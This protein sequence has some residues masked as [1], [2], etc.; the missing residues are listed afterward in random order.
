MNHSSSRSGALPS[1][2]GAWAWRVLALV[3]ASLTVQCG[4]PN[5]P[6]PPPPPPPALTLTC[7]AAV[8]AHSTDGNPRPVQYEAPQAAGGVAPVSISCSVASGAA[9]SVG[10]T[11]VL[12]SATDAR[13]SS[14]FCSFNVRVIAPPRLAYT[15]YLAFGDSITWGVDSPRVPALTALLAPEPP[16]A[17]SYPNRLRERL[18]ERYP[19]QS[20]SMLNAGIPGEYAANIPGQQSGVRR[21][22]DVL[23]TY[24]P[25]VVLLMEG[26]NDLL[27]GQNGADAAIAALDAM[28]AEAR[29]RDRRVCLATIPPQRP[30]GVRNRAAVA[31]LIPGFN[32]RIR[33]LAADRG[34]IL[35]DVFNAMNNDLRLIGVDDL[36]PTVEGFQ[37]IADT[38]LAAIAANLQEA[39][40]AIAPAAAVE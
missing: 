29:A 4:S 38:F 31:A 25:E 26:T 32:D 16:P 35:V 12:C 14:A 40:P 30:N 8:E 2:G 7:P 21:F 23:L 13:G 28:I 3:A 36:H 5:T 20:I 22:R 17:H 27:G 34:V 11:N 15:R 1:R 24:N 9:F 39:Q 19:Q 33:A 6:T 18:A 37:V 10:T